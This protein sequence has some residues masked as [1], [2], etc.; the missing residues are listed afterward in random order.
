MANLT[1]D[2]SRATSPLKYLSNALD[3]TVKVDGQVISSSNIL[4]I[5]QNPISEKPPRVVVFVRNQHGRFELDNTGRPVTKTI[6]GHIEIEG[7][8]E[9]KG[10]TSCR[11]RNRGWWKRIEQ[12]V[13][14]W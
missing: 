10:C 9:S 13:K 6:E 8:P 7:E 11:T 4:D 2:P 5:F 1:R 12:R 3:L 14:G